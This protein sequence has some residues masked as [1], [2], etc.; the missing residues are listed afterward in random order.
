[1]EVSLERVP[2]IQKHIIRLCNLSNTPV[3]TATQMLGSMV[4]SPLPSR[5]EVIT[6]FVDSHTSFPDGWI[7]PSS[8][9]FLAHAHRSLM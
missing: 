5:A 9:S 3:I 2:S 6:S 4:H 8:P 1:V 7:I